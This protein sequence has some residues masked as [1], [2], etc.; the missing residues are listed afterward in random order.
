MKMVSENRKN[1]PNSPSNIVVDVRRMTKV[2]ENGPERLRILDDVFLEIAEGET[3]TISGASGCG[4]STLINLIAGLDRP[5]EGTITV[6]GNDVA[7]SREEDLT[8]YRSRIIG[9]IFQ[10]HYLLK[11]FTALEN[12]MLPALMAGTSMGRARETARSLL[13]QVGLDERMDHI[14][15]QLSGGERQRVAVARALVNDPSLILADEPT[16][17]LDAGNAELIADLLFALVTDRGKTMILVTHDRALGAKGNR[18]LTIEKGRIHT[19]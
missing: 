16:G 10:F 8:E 11:D 1:Q 13:R 14:P 9:L 12:V 4:K 6:V 17:N 18:M 19:A 5:T 2:Y 7:S 15:A 3:V